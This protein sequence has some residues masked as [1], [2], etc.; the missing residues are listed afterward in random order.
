MGEEA[1]VA[2]V[3]DQPLETAAAENQVI[4]VV[5]EK[6]EVDHSDH[7]NHQNG[8]LASLKGVESPEVE[9]PEKKQHEQKD[10]KDAS[11]GK[12]SV[13]SSVSETENEPA[14]A[15]KTTE[16]T[17]LNPVRRDAALAR[18][19]TDKRNALICAWEE[20]EKAKID[21]K[22]YKRL[23]AIESWESTKKAVVEV[24]LKEFEEQLQKKRAE[25]DEKMQNKLAEIHKEAEEK[26]AVIEATKG[27]EYVKV[28]ETANTY[29]TTGN[30]PRKF[31]GCLGC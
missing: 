20:N 18:V 4:P 5:E 28:E 1:K 9:A 14:V 26:R 30:T 31:F 15:E 24:Q 19:Q 7:S 27:E 10:Q 3:A 17:P 2:G 11:P 8:T 23:S 16:K 29:R 6:T 22:T 13:S 21:N 25:Y 12:K